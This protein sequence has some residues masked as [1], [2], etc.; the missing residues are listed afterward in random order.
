MEDKTTERPSVSGGSST[1]SQG[2]GRKRVGAEG[3]KNP[4]RGSG[5][6]KERQMHIA[7]YNARTLLSDQK[8]MELEEEL[9][10]IKWDIVG[11]SEI[12]RRG[13]D[14]ITLKSGHLFHFRG[15]EDTSNGGVGFIIHR[16]HTQNII[17]IDSISPRI[18][19][20]VLKINTRYS[21][22]IIQTYAPTTTHSDEETENFYED[23]ET[24]LHA[25]PTY[26]TILTGDFNAKMGFKQ[27]HAETAMG[28]YGYGER[29]ERG[30]RLLNFLHQENLHVMNSFFDKKPQ[31]KWTWIS[32]DGNTKNEIDLIIT[33]KKE[34]I[35]D[36]EVLNR[37][38]IGSDHR[39]IRAK[40]RLNVKM[41]RTRMILKPRKKK[42]IP[43]ENNDKY[44]ETLARHMQNL[45]SDLGDIEQTSNKIIKALKETEKECCPAVT[46]RKE[47]LSQDTKELLNKRRQLTEKYDSNY[48]TLK[49][50]NKNIH[51]SI[52]RDVREANT[53]EITRV[54]EEN[55]SLKVL[56]RYMNST[57]NKKMYRIKSR[58][59]DITTDKM[60]ILEVVESF[61]R[62]LYRRDD[63][64]QDQPMPKITNQG[65]EEMPEVTTSEVKTALSEMKNNKSPGDDGVVIEAI[66]L[67]GNEIIQTLAKLFTECIY[68]GTTPSHWNNAV[69]VLLHK[70]GDITELTNYRPISLL[71]HIYK[72]FTKI[73]TKRLE[74][75]LDFYQPREQAGF[76]SGYG[77]NDHLLVIK[78]LIEKSAEYN[79]PL[80]LIF[81]DY[82]KAF[83]TINQQKMLIALTECRI[84]YRYTN[85]IKHIYQS[86]TASVR[87]SEQETN[88]FS[89]QRGVRQGDT[90]SPKLFTTLLEHTCKRAGLS[91]HGININ[92]EKLSHLRFADDIVLIADRMDDATEML[93][94]LYHASLEVGLKINMT[95][96]QIMTNL[97]LNRNV[98]IAGRDIEQTVA[99]KYLGHE[100][101]L[102]R[103]NQTCELP[104]R[105]GLTWAAFGKLNYIFKS[106]LP[107]C[108][109]RKTFNQC[110]LPVLTYGAET[111]TLT[112]KVV[113]K[114][115]VTQRAMERQMLGVSLRDRIPNEEIRNR[116]GTIDAIERI[117]TLKW[118]WAGHVARL[119]DNRWTRRIVE[120]RP[121]QE[122]F[123]SRGRPPTRWTDDL[124]R[125]SS[126]WMQ[127]AQ[128]RD[129]WKRLRETYVQQ[130]TRM[131]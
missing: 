119:S 118:N 114:I 67:G 124:K 15:E 64:N 14:Q 90:I 11:L 116:T 34:I 13:E 54:I 82:E 120:W 68:Q 98:S 123:R 85:L 100:I 69:I 37:F 74:A 78:N 125:V 41:E 112:R 107:V 20:L 130:W 80:A 110:V 47:K 25:T 61:Y 29:N 131:G 26:Y 115:R 102:G 56:R 93:E 28:K 105:I 19:Y 5:Y 128:S 91:E 59:G 22:K 35:K 63:E 24:A 127:D 3:A 10:T 117:A 40:V 57:G 43:P 30:Q 18:I 111:L 72:L 7:S 17:K 83:D 122:A 23:L 62:E 94:K 99:Y 6:H 2:S 58:E 8:M 86:A 31:R 32:P 9:K 95:K 66:K 70:K 113:D 92:G 46:T 84:D 21:L 48:T 81:V 88:K 87:L 109:K 53:S 60:E 51:R 1:P 101:R 121:R 129:R 49:E 103:D 75:R 97:V 27:D 50:L 65:S 52:R 33:N 77:T 76:R 36:V 96:T 12:R 42:W 71:S 38:S 104:R 39:L 4:R 44:E 89:I 55:K 45:E 106:S 79:K 73:I 126:N 16:K 108:L